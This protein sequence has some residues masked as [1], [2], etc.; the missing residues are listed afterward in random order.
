MSNP[1]TYAALFIC[2]IVPT[3]LWA[4]TNC[5]KTDADCADRARI[6]RRVNIHKTACQQGLKSKKAAD[7]QRW[8]RQC[9]AY[10]SLLM[11][12]RDKQGFDRTKAI[13]K[14]LYQRGCD[15]YK[16]PIACGVY[17]SRGSRKQ[18][19]AAIKKDARYK[20]FAKQSTAACKKGDALH[21]G[22]LMYMFGHKKTFWGPVE[23]AS[24]KALIIK[25]ASASCRTQKTDD[26]CLPVLM[27]GTY[28]NKWAPLKALCE[29]DK[30][31]P[32]C[33]LYGDALKRNTLLWY[34]KGCTLG[35][36]TS[37]QKQAQQ[38]MRTDPKQARKLLRQ[39]CAS[40]LGACLELERLL[41]K[42]AKK[43]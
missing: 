22:A 40:D 15:V 27:A 23:R 17:V 5:A 20:R 32:A 11:F 31:A 14:T 24:I 34:T 35:D 36:A 19:V 12:R 25:H 8:T 26:A 37:C 9:D 2:M 10:L 30:V 3:T 43:R 41:P 13:L 29:K 4:D 6:A 33:R 21:C 1:I 28:T 7:H 16:D 39:A 18:P 42:P 38:T